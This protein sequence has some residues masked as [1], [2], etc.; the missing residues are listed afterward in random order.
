MTNRN[1][2]DEIVRE[3]RT[4]K[5]LLALNLTKDLEKNVQKM[6]LLN[7]AG[8]SASEIAILIGTTPNTVSVALSQAR[9]RSA[10]TKAKSRE[11]RT[12]DKPS[13]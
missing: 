12:D 11:D 4:I 10:K 6:M 7:Q 8:M 1:E 13:T 2:A 3:L 9:A 5:A